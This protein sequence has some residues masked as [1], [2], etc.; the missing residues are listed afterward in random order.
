MRYTGRRS[1]VS[2]LAIISIVLS[3]CGSGNNEES[4]PGLTTLFWLWTT[5]HHIWRHCHRVYPNDRA[6]LAESVTQVDGTFDLDISLSHEGPVLI[7][8]TPANDGS[9]TFLCDFPGGCPDPDNPVS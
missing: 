5:G 9:S 4:P 3:G 7:E 6:V 1:I 8:I 2:A